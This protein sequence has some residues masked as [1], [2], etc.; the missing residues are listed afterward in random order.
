M[1]TLA[2]GDIHGCHTSLVTLLKAARIRLEDRVVFLGDYID[3]GPASKQVVDTLLGLR[4]FCSPIFLRGNHEIMI[5]QTRQGVTEL[6][7]WK[8]YGGWEALVSYGANERLDWA[9]AIPAAHWKFFEQTLDYFETETAILVHA[10]LDRDLDLKDQPPFLLFWERFDVLQPHKSGKRVI[11]GHTAQDF[12]RI[13]DAGFA[14]CIDTGAA[15][16]GWLSC[17]DV[18]TKEFWQANENGEVRSGVL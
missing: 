9:S 8:E 18:D 14:I 7:V 17:L 1:R 15:T 10:C 4:E 2:I 12:G 5:L 3:R 13:N 11:C 16:G 6:N